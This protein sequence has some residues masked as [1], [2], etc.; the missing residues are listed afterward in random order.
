M[1]KIHSIKVQGEKV[2]IYECKSVL[3][4]ES[5]F[6]IYAKCCPGKI[7][8]YNYCMK[9]RLLSWVPMSHGFY[10]YKSLKNNT[11]LDIHLS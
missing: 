4:W 9:Q 1:R 2:S 8:R 6:V 10:N 7:K 11:V 5:A 3:G